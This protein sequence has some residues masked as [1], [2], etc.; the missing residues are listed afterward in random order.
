MADDVILAKYRLE[1]DGFKKDIDEINQKF[2]KTQKDTTQ[3]ADRIGKSFEKVG[4]MIAG[5]FAVDQL[6]QFGKEIIRVTG[7]FQK[8]EAVLTNTLGSNSAAQLAMAE[9][10]QFAAT[11]PFQVAELTD[12]FVKLANQG[13]RPTQDEMRK[14]GDV[15]AS[16]GKS[17]DQLTEAIID[18]QVGEFERLK[19]FGIRAQKQGDQVTFTFKEVETQVDFTADSIR[20]YVLSLGELEGVSGATDA[21]AKTLIGQI[22][23]LKDSVDLLMVS[24]GNGTS[25]ALVDFIQ[26][27]N[28]I[29][30]DTRQIIEL[31]DGWWKSALRV[32]LKIN[33]ALSDAADL[34]DET[35]EKQIELNN[36]LERSELAAKASAEAMD[37]LSDAIKNTALD[38]DLLAETFTDTDDSIGSLAEQ[39]KLTKEFQKN[40]NE[41]SE[42]YAELQIKIW[43]LEQQRAD[44][45]DSIREKYDALNRT[46]TVETEIT[47]KQIKNLD[48]RAEVTREVVQVSVNEEAAARL[49]MQQEEDRRQHLHEENMLQLNESSQV[50]AASFNALGVILNSFNNNSKEMALFQIGIGQAEAIA[51]FLVATSKGAR[52]DAEQ[53]NAAAIA[54]TLGAIATFT[55]ITIANISQARKIAQSEDV[56]R[57]YEGTEYLTG[58]RGKDQIPVLANYGERIIPTLDNARIG[59]DLSNKE[60]VDAALIYKALRKAGGS[61]VPIDYGQ[62][63]KIERKGV[64]TIVNKLDELKAKPKYKTATL[65]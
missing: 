41:E 64:M 5:A 27:L 31:N 18:A 6:V 17:F 29:V 62:L 38:M 56:P 36:E 43:Q 24:I 32:V 65:Q 4:G 42:R 26:S 37:E 15:A 13:F 35:V 50:A 9:I 23:M 12:A 39:I 51:N 53:G 8:F 1:L 47:Q 52:K 14:L 30:T 55:A 7:E 40:F 48:K 10:V 28:E 3:R 33:P 44:N 25:G 11:T 21:I 63:A 19:E 59:R 16:T 20:E 34:L 60:L 57:F 58:A 46:A 49:R 45:L 22:S 54:S 2:D 61:G